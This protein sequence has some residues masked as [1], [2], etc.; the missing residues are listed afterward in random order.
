MRDQYVSDIS[1]YLK[2]SF[3]RGITGATQRLGVAC[4]Y[5]PGYDGRTD[6]RHVEYK[7]E[8]R[9]RDLDPTV[10]DQMLTIKEQSVA[11]LEGLS[12]WPKATIFHRVPVNTQRRDASV[13]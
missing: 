1:D 5:L 12:F 4:Y 10:F 7:N 11:S 13:R 9:W 3:L 6:G 8:R 2:F